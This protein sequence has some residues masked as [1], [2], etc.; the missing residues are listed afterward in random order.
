M[1][2]NKRTMI[3]MVLALMAALLNSSIAIFSK[4]LVFDN[5]NPSSIAFYRAAIV[6]CVMLILSFGIYFIKPT[7]TAKK[8]INAPMKNI[9]IC[10][11]AALFGLFGLFY[12]ETSAY[13]HEMASNVVFIM[14]ASAALSSLLFESAFKMESIS[15]RKILSMSASIFGLLIVF[16]INH[17]NDMRGLLLSVSA[18]VSYGLFSV[19][20]RKTGAK[21]TLDFMRNMFFFGALYLAI[22]AGVD[23]FSSIHVQHIPTLLAL[24]IVPSLFGTLCT[25]KSLQYLPA[26]KVQTIELT[27]PIF[28]AIMAYL[29]IAETPGPLQ[30]LGY[31]FIL[32]GVFCMNMETRYSTAAI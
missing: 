25:I 16:G 6:F 19:H 22:P 26:S 32:T 18:G 31:A 30:M 28:V 1:R 21:A 2:L 3:G 29:L 12:F 17:L 11:I 10:A 24:A 13:K 27:E 15:K 9:E 8:I 4:Q 7:R 23:G 20:I 5:I 14:M